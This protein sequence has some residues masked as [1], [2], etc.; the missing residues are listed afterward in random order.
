MGLE[1]TSRICM[2]HRRPFSVH[3]PFGVIQCN[4][5]TCY[6]D[7]RTSSINI[8]AGLR[9]GEVT[10]ASPHS[11]EPTQEATATVYKPTRD[12]RKVWRHG[13]LP[14]MGEILGTRWTATARLKLDSAQSRRCC[15]V[16]AYLP[17]CVLG[18]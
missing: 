16:T 17:Y 10:P 14:T 12:W 6:M 13:L 18:D 4:G 11:V 2:G 8:C 7:N 5:G 1:D 15:P 9:P 3:G